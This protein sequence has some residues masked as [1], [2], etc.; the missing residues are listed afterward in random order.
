MIRADER[1]Q[2]LLLAF[3]LI[4]DEPALT[5]EQVAERIGTTTKVLMRD[6]AS[7]ERYDT[8]AGFLET[9]QVTIEPHGTTMRS[10]HFKRPPRL[11]RPE[12]LALELG[13]GMLEQELPL[14][15]RDLVR[16]ARTRLREVSVRRSSSV[17]D[18]RR[19]A[20]DGPPGADHGVLGA[21]QVQVETAPAVELEVLACLQLA[22][23]QRQVVDLTY[24]RPDDTVAASRR[25]R[26]Y[27]LVRAD[28]TVYLVAHC[29]RADALRVFRLDRVV[30]ADATPDPFDVPADFTVQQVLQHGRVFHREEPA[31][32]TLTIRYSPRVARW[33]AEREQ[34]TP[35]D[36]G[37]LTVAYPLAD[38]TWAVRHVLQYGPDATILAP[39]ALRERVTDLLDA[40]L[41]D[42][43]G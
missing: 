30:A 2:R 6:F 3:P 43:P 40:M 22:L 7:L 21:A 5:V 14:H 16:R 8:P 19:P 42:S 35:D 1:L 29:E 18:A 24:R 36:D 25:V 13:L 23:E 28:A 11:S 27:A 37:S 4:A 20:S 38:E 10:A 12:M 17:A 34:R 15:E 41:Q 26:P 39:V 32:D 9:V 33:I 31:D